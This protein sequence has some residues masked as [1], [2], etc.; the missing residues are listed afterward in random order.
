MLDFPKVPQNKRPSQQSAPGYHSWVLMATMSR[1]PNS[2]EHKHVECIVVE[3]SACEFRAVLPFG[4][5][6]F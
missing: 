6:Q 3:V 4:K 1:T 2:I 5:E